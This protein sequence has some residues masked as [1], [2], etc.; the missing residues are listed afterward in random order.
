[1]KTNIQIMKT[2]LLTMTVSMSFVLFTS[3]TSKV[4]ETISDVKITDLPFNRKS[5]QLTGDK[6]K[7]FPKTN[8]GFLWQSD[9]SKTKKWRPQGI[10]G[11]TVGDREF[12]IVSW[13][14]RKAGSYSNRGARIS[15]VDITKLKDSPSENNYR[16]ILLLDQE[17][18]TFYDAGYE[19]DK[20]TMH[21]G[22]IA[23]VNGKLHV[24][25]S[26]GAHRVIRVFDINKSQKRTPKILNYE[27]V[28]VEEYNYKA[29]IKPS[30]MSY[31]KDRNQILMGTFA[32][33]PSADNPNLMTWFTP[34]TASEVA[35]FNQT[36]NQIDVY[37]L[38]NKY[39]K[40]QGMVASKDAT[41]KQILWLSTSY[42]A[43]N[44][45]NFY[46]FNVNIDASTTTY[47]ADA[48]H[49]LTTENSKSSKYP[50]GLEDL[51]LAQSNNLWLLTEFAYAEGYYAPLS[52]ST[53][54][55][56]AEITK[57]KKTRRGVFCIKKTD[58]LP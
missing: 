22:G 45:S 46:K 24:A 23:L 8:M 44:R 10:T 34:P 28:L 18:N 38:P 36:T 9:D 13:Y 14:G 6:K 43:R 35:S 19:G 27:Y 39:K 29:P 56:K 58:I 42:G 7:E 17:G 32:K 52:Y 53:A 37:R 40:I 51:Y 33:S 1:M 26:R 12:V 15:V 4:E 3:M 2:L 50:P 57:T 47:Q 54:A 48:S 16:H 41:G 30:F 11:M 55:A 49:T 21:A 20:G 31:D 5:V 25:D